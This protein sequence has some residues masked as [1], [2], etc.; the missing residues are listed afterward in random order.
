MKFTREEVLDFR[1]EI[2]KLKLG[3]QLYKIAGLRIHSIMLS[4]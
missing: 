2:V 4:I 1:N 3:I